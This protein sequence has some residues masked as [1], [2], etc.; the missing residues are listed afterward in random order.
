M[1]P[2]SADCWVMSRDRRSARRRAFLLRP[3][4]GQHFD[5][6]GDE[7]GQGLDLSLKRMAIHEQGVLR[8]IHFV[9]GLAQADEIVGDAGQAGVEGF[10]RAWQRP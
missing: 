2:A 9:D 10:A 5:H 1:R 4:R 8:V 3:L 7:V 6:V